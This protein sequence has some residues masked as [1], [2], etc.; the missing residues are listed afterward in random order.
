MTL[1][2]CSTAADVITAAQVQGLHAFLSSE[3]KAAATDTQLE[4]AAKDSNGQWVAP[5]MPGRNCTPA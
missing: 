2:E 1:N 3:A 5:S 4:A